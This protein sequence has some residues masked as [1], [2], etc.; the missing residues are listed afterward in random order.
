MPV[1]NREDTLLRSLESVGEQ[2]FRNFELVI[3]DDGSSDASLA[4][5]REFAEQNAGLRVRILEHL[6]NRGVSAARNTG[7]EA[8]SGDVICYLDSDNEWY[9][10]TLGILV[11]QL[12]LNNATSVYAGQEI[13]EYLPAFDTFDRRSVRLCPFNRSRLER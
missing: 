12:V 6:V 2:T 13:I 11:S 8:C 5:A 3:V 9:P 4:I 7:I 1:F 10:E